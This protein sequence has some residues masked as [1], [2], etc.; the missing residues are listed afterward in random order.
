M[1]SASAMGALN[2]NVFATARLCV[3]ASKR[4]YFPGILAN[5][6]IRQGEEESE[7]YK[8]KLERSPTI[9]RKTISSFASLT[10]TLRIEKGVPV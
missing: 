9:I 8:R 5:M 4:S 6:H 7:Y 3:A 2:A 1:I 10:N